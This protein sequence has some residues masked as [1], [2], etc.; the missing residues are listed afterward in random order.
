MRS[1]I[2]FRSFSPF[3]Y[4]PDLLSSLVSLQMRV[5]APDKRHAVSGLTFQQPVVVKPLHELV[6]PLDSNPSAN[7]VQPVHD[8]AITVIHILAS[9]HCI[10][11]VLVVSTRQLYCSVKHT[12]LLGYKNVLSKLKITQSKYTGS[13]KTKEKNSTG[14]VVL[15]EGVWEG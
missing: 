13:K 8:I 1:I 7:L 6:L 5:Q 11:S 14:S 15:V 12:L 10:D 4:L 3:L 9:S 2:D